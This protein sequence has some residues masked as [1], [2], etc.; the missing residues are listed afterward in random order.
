MML[1]QR[2]VTAA[3]LIPMVLFLIFGLETHYFAVC[4]GLLV[5]IGA[6]EWA[7]LSALRTAMAY[8]YVLVFVA[9]L[10]LILVYGDRQWLHVIVITGTIW[11]LFCLLP[12]LGCRA[13]RRILFGHGLIRAGMGLV[14]LIPAWASLLLLHGH[15][16]DGAGILLFLMLLIWVTDS[17]A[18]FVGRKWG[19]TPLAVNISPGKT[20]EGFWGGLC[21]GL[22]LGL[23]YVPVFDMDAMNACLF[24]VV[25]LITI[26]F[27]VLGDLME[28]MLKRQSSAKDSG[29]ILPGHGGILDRVDSV[30]AAGPVFVTGMLGAGLLK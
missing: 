30:A 15:V 24:L 10:G 2:L 26:V 17:G 20:W 1:K 14:T 16:S 23:G 9:G 28:S 7:G 12:I 5:C 6:W 8:L 22:L 27:S 18:Y 29:H 11:W 4:L 21:A 25:C 3:I 19:H 13:I